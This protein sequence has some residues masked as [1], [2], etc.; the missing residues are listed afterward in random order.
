MNLLEEDASD[1]LPLIGGQ[2]AWM[3]GLLTRV[4]VPAS[5]TSIPTGCT[6]ASA[7]PGQRGAVRALGRLT[8][9]VASSASRSRMRLLDH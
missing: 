7:V 9:T 2:A 6:A 1:Q 5:T 8:G 3:G 4:G